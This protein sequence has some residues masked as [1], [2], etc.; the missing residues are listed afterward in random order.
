M[1]ELDA[2]MD[3]AVRTILASAPELAREEVEEELRHY[4]KEFL[5]GP[6]DAIRAVTRK[7]VHKHG[8]RPEQVKDA[9]VGGPV[10]KVARFEELA[11]GERNVEIEVRVQSSQRRP[12][13]VRGE[14]RM[15]GWG[16]IED[17]PHASNEGR[18]TWEFKDWGD[19]SEQLRPGAVV[20]LEGTSVNEYQGRFSLNINQTSRV[21]V[22]EEGREVPVAG[23][24]PLS[25]ADA[26]A[27][28]GPV[29]VVAR[30]MRKESRSFTPRDGGADRTMIKGQLGDASGLLGFTSWS[31]FD[32]EVGTLLKIVGGSVRRF[33][34][35]PE[36]NVNDSTRI[37]VFHDGAFPELDA[38]AGHAQ[39]T[40]AELK[41]GVRDVDL[42][43][44]LVSLE[45]REVQVKGEPRTVWGGELIDPTG[46]CRMTAWSDPGLSD[47]KLPLAVRLNG[48][49]VRAWQ[50]IPDVTLDDPGQ[51]DRLDAV[52]WDAIDPD[53]HWVR[54]PLSEAVQASRAGVEIVATAV[55]LRDTSGPVER[56]PECRRVLRDGACTDH[57]EQRGAADLRLLI[58]L[59]DGIETA[60][61]VVG[62]EPSEAF[63]GKTLQLV[64]QEVAERGLP[65][66]LDEWRTG[67]LGRPLRVRGRIIVD[68]QG[69]MFLADTIARVDE[70][71]RLDAAAVR[72]RWGVA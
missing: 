9:D 40:I 5:I 11:N 67:M 37:E 61:I 12:Q 54:T 59:D 3:Y 51:V 7:L 31:A 14:E 16:R 41:D 42:V 10:R 33:R 50:G 45:P 36:L 65:H 53:D 15:V 21:V 39:L 69:G 6:R 28:E 66:V 32:H 55:A 48:V 63:L 43:A 35:T 17:Q 62:R 64:Q 34:D 30:V 44:E 2:D 46:R 70:S 24:E 27:I 1:P 8:I 18:T 13:T 20:R 25:L 68:D 29:T 38:L 26:S 58:V 49:R 72:S 52:P 71:E 4:Q 57:G 22:L 19:H 23:D 56:C 47:A 60:S